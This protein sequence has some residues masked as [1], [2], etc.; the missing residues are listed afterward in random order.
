MHRHRRLT[1]GMVLAAIGA[2]AS[3]LG[4][5]GATDPTESGVAAAEVPPVPLALAAVDAT[6]SLRSAEAGWQAARV[7]VG[8]YELSFPGEVRL[9]LGTWNAVADVTA[10]PVSPTTW[11]VLFRAGGEVPVD[12]SFTFLASPAG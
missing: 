4:V 5:A 12:S 3:W 11:I 2:I 9:A 10:R 8:T 6:G 7:D 1:V